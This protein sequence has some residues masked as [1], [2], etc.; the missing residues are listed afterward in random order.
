[1]RASVLTT[2]PL[3]PDPI[4]EE[5]PCE[6]CPQPCVS[7][8]P[9]KAISPDRDRIFVMEGREFHYGWLSYLKCQWCCGGMVENENT[10]AQSDVP[11]P[12]LDEEDDAEKVRLEFLLASENRYPWDK[13][14]RG[15]F[16][17]NACSK[18]YIVCHPERLKKKR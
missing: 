11:M 9:V 2:A 7:I 18:C 8:C 16:T 10:D 14:N 15:A 17:F 5:D 13:V 12:L 6:G 4:L 1:M 3:T